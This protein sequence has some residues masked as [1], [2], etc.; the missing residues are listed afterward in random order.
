VPRYLVTARQRI[1]YGNQ[2]CEI[3]VDAES[4][5]A[6]K[7]EAKR[8]YVDG[9]LF[10]SVDDVQDVSEPDYEIELEKEVEPAQ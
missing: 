7:Q 10:F 9:M 3:E 6:A 2:S 1:H 4:E 5:A 8:R